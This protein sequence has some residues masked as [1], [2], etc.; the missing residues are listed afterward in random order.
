MSTGFDA[1]SLVARILPG[2][3]AITPLILLF[4]FMPNGVALSFGG[5]ALLFPIVYFIAYQIGR[6]SGK[7]KEK[8]LWDKWGGAPTTRFLRHSNKEY[9]HVDREVIHRKL[10]NMNI[11]VPTSAQE[12]ANKTYADA[13]YMTAVFVLRERTRNKDNFP[14]VFSTLTIYGFYRNLWGLKWAALAI[15]LV[16]FAGYAISTIQDCLSRSE[17]ASISAAVM[18]NTGLLYIWVFKVRAAKVKQAAEE[19]A[20][21]LLGAARAMEEI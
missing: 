3:I 7:S 21:A 11:E 16:S 18:I 8:D 5:A 4:L 17:I 13:C 6:D 10:E 9:D 1:Y 19:Y 15:M 2:Y 14:L 20:R 12:E